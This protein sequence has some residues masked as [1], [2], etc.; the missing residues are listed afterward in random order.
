MT[1]QNIKLTIMFMM[2]L[3]GLPIACVSWLLDRY[4]IAPDMPPQNRFLGTKEMF[5]SL[6]VACT[7]FGAIVYSLV[8]ICE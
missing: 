8:K 1:K 5:I 6:M 2:G 4:V 7:V 3:P